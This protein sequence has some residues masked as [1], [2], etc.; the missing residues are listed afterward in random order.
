MIFNFSYPLVLWNVQLYLLSIYYV[1]DTVQGTEDGQI[2][3]TDPFLILIELNILVG[4]M[5]NKTTNIISDN[6]K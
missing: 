4:E 2:N 1:L 3:K 6:R 5:E